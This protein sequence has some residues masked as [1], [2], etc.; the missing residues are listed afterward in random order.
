MMNSAFS[1]IN[2]STNVRILHTN[3]PQ[4]EPASAATEEPHLLIR[5]LQPSDASGVQAAFERMSPLSRYYRF[6]SG[7]RRLP[8]SMLHYLTHVDG[9]DHVALVA[10]ERWGSLPPV[11]VGIARFVRLAQAPDTAELAIAVVDQAQGRGIGRRLLQELAVVA[12]AH[13]VSTFT[14]AVLAGNRRVRHLLAG[15]GASGSGT[16]ASVIDYRVPV[17]AL[18]VPASRAHLLA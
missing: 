14:M 18:E 5:P 16:D 13:G 12:R 4:P 3:E 15:L 8:D 2:N 7:L 9:I 1:Y 10:I 6:H 11:G 17:A